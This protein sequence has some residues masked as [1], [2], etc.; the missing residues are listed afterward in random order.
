MESGECGGGGMRRS[1]SWDECGGGVAVRAVS[2][3]KRCPGPGSW[4]QTLRMDEGLGL[5]ETS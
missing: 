1:A 2:R 4:L 5:G 3:E